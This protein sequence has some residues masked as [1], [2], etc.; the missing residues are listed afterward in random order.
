MCHPE[1]KEIFADVVRARVPTWSPRTC[2]YLVA[3]QRPSQTL[4]HRIMQAPLGPMLSCAYVPG[5]FRLCSTKEIQIQLPSQPAI[6]PEQVKTPTLDD[7][8]LVCLPTTTCAQ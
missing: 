7:P 1:K 6:H 4:W 2:A 5:Q 8:S 3:G